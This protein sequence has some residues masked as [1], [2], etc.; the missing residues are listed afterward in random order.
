VRK[1]AVMSWR[2]M[3]GEMQE[4]RMRATRCGIY[5][6]PVYV[7]DDARGFAQLLA[8]CERLLARLKPDAGVRL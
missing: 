6:A 2:G 8:G 3:G 5:L 7:G 4:C 1:S